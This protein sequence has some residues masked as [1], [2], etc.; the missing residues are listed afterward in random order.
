MQNDHGRGFKVAPEARSRAN[1]AL[2]V[3]HPPLRPT[4]SATQLRPVSRDEPMFQRPLRMPEGCSTVRRKPHPV[5]VAVD[6]LP[7][8]PPADPLPT[9]PSRDIRRVKS[10][11]ALTLSAADASS[12]VS[13]KA[14]ET[15]RWKAA[16]GEAQY[17]AGGLVSRPAESTKH[18][19]IIRHSNALVW[20][21]G[22][23]TSVSISILSDEPLPEARKLWLQE[24]GFTGG[25]GMSLKACVGSTAGW[26]DVTPARQ[27]QV[28]HLDEGDERAIQRDLKRFAKKASARLAKHVARE[29]HV[30]R[31]PAVAADGYF[32]LVLGAGKDGKKVLCGSPVFRIASTSTDVAVVRGASLSTMPLEVGVK[33]ASTIGQQM[34][35]KYAGLAGA[36][37]QN[38]ATKVA[39]YATAKKVGHT[40]YQ[41]YQKVGLADTVSSSWEQSR[42]KTYDPLVRGQPSEPLIATVGPEAGPEPPFPLKFQGRVARASGRSSDELGFP[43][44]NLAEVPEPIRVRLGGVFAAWAMVL[45]GKGLEDVCHD[46]LEAVVTVAPPRGAPPSVA[47]HNGVTVHIAYD[48]DGATFFD[49]KV[50]ILLMGYL[51]PA[52]ATDDP[53]ELAGEHAQDVMTTLASLGRDAWRP[54]E[55]VA[56][57]KTVKSERSFGDRV[58]DATGKMVQHVDRIP[59]HKAGVRSK[60]ATRRD[61]LLGIGGLWIAR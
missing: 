9:S 8:P 34:A 36:V 42:Q 50:K 5:D 7:P 18:H 51:H 52:S 30:V 53:A 13:S 33:F 59:L 28:E 21:K 49:A 16:L 55:T 22:P 25:V 20:Y 60:S 4:R 14:R 11:S 45:P 29:T 19:S 2:A 38:R 47:M 43:T 1:V 27:A 35:K 31:I 12:A 23:T 37:V 40:A 57:M 6:E 61:Q 39:H 10:S 48:F 3:P 58:N 54:D 15:S 17:F 44:A 24:K 41:G 46:W 26:L 56:Q 32:R